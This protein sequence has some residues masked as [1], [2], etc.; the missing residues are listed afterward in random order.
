[1]SIICI[2]S[3]REEGTRGKVSEFTLA[4][5]LKDPDEKLNSKGE[6]SGEERFVSP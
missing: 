2:E 3:Q 4:L 5:K 1:M 6:V